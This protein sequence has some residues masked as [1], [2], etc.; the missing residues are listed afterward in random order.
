MYLEDILSAIAR[1]GEYTAKGKE[2]FFAHGLVQ[3]GVIRQL[4]IIGEASTKLPMTLKTQHPEIP[5]K[6]V[7]AMRNIIVHDYSEINLERIWGTIE[8]DL[9]VL[10]KAIAAMLRESASF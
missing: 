8:R 9:P 4:S 10:R 2:N 1:I 7:T 6:E 3:D 5:W